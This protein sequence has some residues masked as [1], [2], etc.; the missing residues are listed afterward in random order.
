MIYTANEDGY[1]GK[2]GRDNV[3]QQ[4]DSEAGTLKHDVKNL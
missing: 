1:L 3:I 2:A 4:E